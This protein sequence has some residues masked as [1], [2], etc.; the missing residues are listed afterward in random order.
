MKLTSPIL[1]DLA[2][3][4][5]TGNPLLGLAVANEYLTPSAPLHQALAAKA[6]SRMHEGRIHSHEL[7]DALLRGRRSAELPPILRAQLGKRSSFPQK[8]RSALPRQVQ[9]LA[10]Q[11]ARRAP[12]R[13]AGEQPPRLHVTL[14]S[15]TAHHLSLASP[16]AALQGVHRSS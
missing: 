9:G 11:G 12:E 10:I 3:Q 1:R 16:R 5:T 2:H 8:K 13:R 7:L 4:I 14:G 6:R 15:R